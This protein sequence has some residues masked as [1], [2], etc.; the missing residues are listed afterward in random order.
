MESAEFPVADKAVSQDLAAD[1]LRSWR[2]RFSFRIG[3]SSAHGYDPDERRG[4]GHN[5]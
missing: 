1:N 4:N 2:L 3:G 5:K